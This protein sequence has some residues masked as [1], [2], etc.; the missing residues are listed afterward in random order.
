MMKL[1]YKVTDSEPRTEKSRHTVSRNLK[2]TRQHA[3]RD[4]RMD[5]VTDKGASPKA[6]GESDQFTVLGRR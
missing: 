6:C 5:D 4:S 2:M 3:T 1:A